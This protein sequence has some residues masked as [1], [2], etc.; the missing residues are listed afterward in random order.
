MTRCLSLKAL[1]PSFLLLVF[2][3]IAPSSVAQIDS[4]SRPA[5]SLS[6][7]DT[8]IVSGNEHTKE[9][10]ILNEMTLQAGSV[11]TPE[12]IEFDRN[13]IYSLGLF[14]R[15]DIF[16]DSLEGV[17]FLNV[18]V[19]E[20]WYLIPVPLLGFRD[21]DLKK[22]FFGGGLL[23]NNVRGR[24]QKLFASVVFGYNPSLSLFFAD[25]LIDRDNRLFFSGN[26]SYSRV[27]NQSKIEASLTGDF[28]ER[29]Y[30]LN[31]TLGKRLNLYASA[32][33]TLGYRI[34]EVDDYRPGRTISPTGADRFLYGT[35]SYAYDSRDLREYASRGRY[36]SLSMTK[37]GFG[38]SEMRYTRFGAD[39]REYVPLPLDLVLAARVH[40]T[41][42]SGGPVPSYNWAYFGYGER[43]RGYFNSVFE[44]ENLL[45]TTVELRFPL[46]KTRT[47]NVSSLPLP[48]QFTVWRFGI[49]LSVFADAGLTWSRGD[50]LQLGSFASG[51]GAGV[52]FL[53]PYSYV[54][55][56]EYAYNEYFKGQAIL[57]LRGP[58]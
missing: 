14:T 38:E 13:R 46:L 23:H 50:K 25:P 24:N 57:N 16:Y 20:R 3:C 40:G 37:F 52:I 48:A 44:G 33:L 58:I 32:G 47:I 43:I 12:A 19:G 17:R 26:L 5:R 28:D 22:V 15:V 51:Y 29:H 11:P 1:A 2:F 56:T 7:I 6:S 30:D 41:V 10:V 21:G 34:V 9:Y 31:A 35:I 42:V 18:D 54:V 4:L 45:G 36:V 53:L 27:R 55:R 8:I 49:S 39:L